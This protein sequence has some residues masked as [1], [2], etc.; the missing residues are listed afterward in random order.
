MAIKGLEVERRFPVE[1]KVFKEVE[2]ELQKAKEY[3][4]IIDTYY[5]LNTDFRNVFMYCN[6]TLISG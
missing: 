6:Y 4:N 3:Q 2:K 5:V 1:P